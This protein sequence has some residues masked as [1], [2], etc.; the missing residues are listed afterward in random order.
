MDSVAVTLAP[1]GLLRGLIDP[2]VGFPALEQVR[3]CFY[4]RSELIV[5]FAHTRTTEQLYIICDRTT[6]VSQCASSVP[7]CAPCCP[8][9]NL[10]ESRTVPGYVAL[11][12]C[13]RM[14]KAGCALWLWYKWSV[15]LINKKCSQLT[16]FISHNYKEIYCHV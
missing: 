7:E 5:A 11:L 9:L 8:K 15:I 1:F 2:P 14:F 10:G 6:S 12:R 4:A 13:S 3:T 16:S